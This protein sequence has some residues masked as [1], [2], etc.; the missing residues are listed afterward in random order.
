MVVFVCAGTQSEFNLFHLE[1][2]HTNHNNASQH[3]LYIRG[4]LWSEATHCVVVCG[5][6]YTHNVQKYNYTLWCLL[7]WCE[8]H[9]QIM[10]GI[11]SQPHIHYIGQV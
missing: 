1:Y 7:V 2:R 6:V 9:T 11:I 5:S 8:M 4:A 3:S 10:A